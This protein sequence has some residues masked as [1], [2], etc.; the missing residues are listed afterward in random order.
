VLA[1]MVDVLRRWRAHWEARPIAI[2][3]MPSD[4]FDRLNRSVAEH[5]G[6]IGKLPV[7]DALSRSRVSL[8]P[9]ASSGVV[10]RALF[11]AFSLLPDQVVPEGPILLVDARYRSGWAMTVGASL[12][13]KSGAT[14][15]MP[16]VVHQLP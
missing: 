12:L 9:D 16:L 5:L 14:A 15:V 3:P 1:G 4:E 7:F 11:D 13:R 10:V 6:T 2:V 8:P